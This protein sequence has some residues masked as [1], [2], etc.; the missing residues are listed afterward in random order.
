MD[1]HNVYAAPLSVAPERL[2]SL[3]VIDLLHEYVAPDV[4][5]EN[6]GMIMSVTVNV[7]P[8]LFPARSVTTN[9]CT[10]SVR[11][12]SPELYASPSIVAHERLVS[13]KVIYTPPVT[14]PVVTPANVG[15]V[16]SIVN[17]APVPFQS[18][19]TT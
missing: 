13:E 1:A 17:V 11:N 19:F 16:L 6:T 14:I 10:H 9:V 7:A 15:C 5:P 12:G 4:T 18:V 8:V 2:I 3:N